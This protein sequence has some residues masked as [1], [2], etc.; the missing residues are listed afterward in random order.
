MATA[1]TR[2]TIAF[3]D[4]TFIDFERLSRQVQTTGPQLLL[5]RRPGATGTIA[6]KLGNYGEPFEMQG[7]RTFPN[8]QTAVQRFE[9]ARKKQGQRCEVYDNAGMHFLE[10]LLLGLFVE[11]VKP[12]ALG[13]GGIDGSFGAIAVIRVLLIQRKPAAATYSGT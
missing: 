1:P 7:V 8:M 11:E 9:T 6:L 3:A 2:S 10:C 4:E 5:A 13:I 12:V